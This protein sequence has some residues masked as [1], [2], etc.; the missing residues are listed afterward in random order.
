MTYLELEQMMWDR[1]G[2][3]ARRAEESSRLAGARK[4]G[5]VTRTL[6][7]LLRAAADRLE[8]SPAPDAASFEGLRLV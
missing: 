5:R 2:E 6:A 1:A 4:A 3:T 7:A 8:P